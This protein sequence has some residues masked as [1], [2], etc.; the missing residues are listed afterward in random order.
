MWWVC[1]VCVLRLG[2]ACMSVMCVM[3]VMCVSCVCHVMC[4]CLYVFVCVYHCVMC[5][6]QGYLPCTSCILRRL[7]K[8]ERKHAKPE[9][10]KTKKNKGKSTVR[11]EKLAGWIF[12]DDV[13]GPFLFFSQEFFFQV[14]LY[15]TCVCGMH[16][17]LPR[18]SSVMQRCADGLSMVGW[19]MDGIGYHGILVKVWK[20]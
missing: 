12:P 15:C 8:H 18:V 1:A 11:A 2:F 3:R 6:W 20:S 9:N 19:G 4:M 14:V 17:H 13:F 16:A 7:G 10:Q 5:V